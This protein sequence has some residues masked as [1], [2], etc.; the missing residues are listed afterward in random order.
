M[1]T[2]AE[3]LAA[4]EPDLV[5]LDLRLPGHGRLHRLPRAPRPLG[6]ADHRR[7][8]EGRG[9]RPRR[10]P[11]ARGGRLRRE[12]VR[13]PRARRA[14]PRRHAADRRGRGEAPET[15]LTRRR[16]RGRLRA[17]RASSSAARRSRSPRRSSTSWP[18]SRSE[19]G[20]V[21]S[22]QRILEEVWQTTWYGSAKTIDV[23]VASLRRKLGDP[24]WIETVRGVGLR[25]RADVSRRLLLGLPRPHRA[26]PGGARGAARDHAGA[27]RARR[28]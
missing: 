5:L 7:D 21:V 10:R 26:R 8:R 12:A 2:G 18:C 22:R 13:P 16:A 9:G 20:A 17:H 14:D 24:G 11:R 19:P 3:A 15:R 28:I 23:H 1:A 6:R 4:P 27:Q 25:L